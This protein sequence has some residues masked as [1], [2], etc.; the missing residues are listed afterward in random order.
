LPLFGWNP[1]I[2]AIFWTKSGNSLTF[3]KNN[4]FHHV[5]VFFFQKNAHW[6]LMSC[7]PNFWLFFSFA[8]LFW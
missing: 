6:I 5:Q 2:F 8:Q 3:W 4:I 7:K 1:G